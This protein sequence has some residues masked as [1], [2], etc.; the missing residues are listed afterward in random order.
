MRT[1]ISNMQLCCSYSGIPEFSI[2]SSLNTVHFGKILFSMY[3]LSTLS[4]ILAASKFAE[5][6][7]QLS[8]A[9][10]TT[11]K[12]LTVNFLLKALRSCTGHFVRID[13]ASLFSSR[14]QKLESIFNELEDEGTNGNLDICVAPG[15]SYTLIEEYNVHDEGLGHLEIKE[16]S[17]KRT[18]T[19]EKRTFVQPF[20]LRG[21]EYVASH[22]D[23]L[24][25]NA[26]TD[27]KEYTACV[28]N[29]IHE[30]MSEEFEEKNNNQAVIMLI[31]THTRK[32]RTRQPK[33]FKQVKKWIRDF[34][35]PENRKRID[36]GLCLIDV[37]I[38]DEKGFLCTTRLVDECRTT[39][40]HNIDVAWAGFTAAETQC[41]ITVVIAAAHSFPLPTVLLLLERLVQLKVE[42]V[43]VSG[44][45]HSIKLLV[46]PH[47]LQIRNRHFHPLQPFHRC[48]V[49]DTEF[50]SMSSPKLRSKNLSLPHQ[51]CFDMQKQASNQLHGDMTYKLPLRVLQSSNHITGLSP[52]LPNASCIQHYTS[53]TT[54]LDIPSVR[55]HL[56]GVA[57]NKMAASVWTLAPVEETAIK[58]RANKRKQQKVKQS[59]ARS[60]WK[61]MHL[62]MLAANPFVNTAKYEAARQMH[63]CDR[64]T[65]VCTKPAL[66]RNQVLIETINAQALPF[67]L[68]YGI[69][70][71][72]APTCVLLLPMHTPC[73]K[74][75]LS[76]NERHLQTTVAIYSLLARLNE[77]NGT[78]TLY[79]IGDMLTH[80]QYGRAALRQLQT[81]PFE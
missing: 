13:R 79:V 69:T 39:V 27:C 26:E 36:S 77:I 48:T 70:S 57:G 11:A 63:T 28:Q 16:R 35:R 80:V 78:P 41:S 29:A 47:D 14:G 7:G 9:M 34:I 72:D 55:K 67:D 49:D 73:D 43:E 60:N 44:Q 76:S 33:A 5:T 15:S 20:V 42:T 10:C 62:Q 32:T 68:V 37:P 30:C 61:T 46:D 8:N 24:G 38:L 18:K 71:F 51:I 65:P 21:K 12:Q 81:I 53:L 25:Y 4:G 2:L 3:D 54:A 66:A 22:L 50:E 64:P 52:V 56:L 19:P 17:C 75:Q 74:Q 40:L 58:P 6:G 1:S 59:N 45:K 31:P 23:K